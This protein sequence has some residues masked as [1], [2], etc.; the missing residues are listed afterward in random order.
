LILIWVISNICECLTMARLAQV[1]APGYPHHVIQR[2]NRRQQTFFCDE[3]Y[4]PAL[5]SV[6]NITKAIILDFILLRMYISLM[7]FISLT[8]IC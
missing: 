7:Y 6:N 1:I 2:G 8:L 3:D 4:A 5:A